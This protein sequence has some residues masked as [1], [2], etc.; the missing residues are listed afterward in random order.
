MSMARIDEND[1]KLILATQKGL[2]LE[3]RP[4][5][6]IAELTGIKVD[7]VISRFKRMQSEGIIRRIGAVPN[8][9]AL[10]YK[11]NGMAV[12][13]VADEKIQELG[14]R[15]GS[16]DFVSHSYH[17]PRRLPEWSYNLFAMVHGRDREDVLSRIDQINNILKDSVRAHDVLFSTRILKKTGLRLIREKQGE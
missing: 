15:V 11:A 8:H 17:R 2:P 6:R 3:P 7:E 16:L 10:G 1:R 9:Y 13:D 14:R 4:Y 12:W 5:H